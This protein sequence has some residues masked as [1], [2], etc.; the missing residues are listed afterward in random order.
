MDWELLEIYKNFLTYS[1]TESFRTHKI[2]IY[3]YYK[4][5]VTK[6]NI[7]EIDTKRRHLFRIFLFLLPI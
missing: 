7:T 4:N 5:L 1:Q 2:W 3:I 6:N